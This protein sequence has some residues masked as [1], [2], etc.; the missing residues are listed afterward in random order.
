MHPLVIPFPEDPLID[1]LLS[2][3]I[4]SRTVIRYHKSRF[5]PIGISLYPDL[6]LFVMSYNVFKDI[7]HKIIEGYSP[8]LKK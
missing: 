7:F 4:H 1:I 6:N 3:C 2:L 5:L 8:T